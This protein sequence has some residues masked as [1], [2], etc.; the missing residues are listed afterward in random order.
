MERQKSKPK[1]AVWLEVSLDALLIAA[2]FALA[3]WIRYSLQW[4]SPVAEENFEPFVTYAPMGLLMV[5][6]L[7]IVYALHKVYVYRRGRSWFDETITLFSG[8]LNGLML[9]IVLTYFIPEL[10]YS[11]GLFPLA[12]M[13]IIGLLAISRIIKQ[14]ILS[15]L[16][17]KGIGVRR[18]LVVGAGEVGRAVM[19]SIVA[20]PEM[21]Y[22][23]VGFVDDEPAKRVNMGKIK[24]LGE[25]DQLPALICERQIDLVVTTLP[26]MYHRKILRIMRQCEGQRCQVYI[27]PDLLETAIRRVDVEYLGEV[28]VMGVREEALGQGGLLLKRGIDLVLTVIALL[29]GGPLMLL[30]ALWIKLDSPG[31][32]IFAQTRIGKGGVPFTCLK[33]RTMRQG[34]D[35]EKARLMS[36]NEGE[37][38]LFKI[39]NDPRVTRAGRWLRR[40]SLDELPQLFNVLRGEMSI[41]GPRPQVPREVELYLEWHRHRL[42]A[43]PGITGMWQVSGRS[44]LSFDE[45]VLL[46]IWYVENWSLLLD[47]KILVKTA[48][49]VL[50]RQG[51]Y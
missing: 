11:R 46:D 39:K 38:R 36:L 13:T 50:S 42:D 27:V 21:G 30:I 22:T 15:R 1:R 26:W 31:P 32:V 19:R 10:S 37:E 6:L 25:I 35:A 29:V 12:A 28:P 33:F 49:V 47:L 9:L 20:H 16:R 4:P 45:M 8:T 41:V 43:L 3:Y 14:I 34:A 24:A 40:F 7:L 18:V 5:A 48:G 23:V 17:K 2:G 44:D 51:A